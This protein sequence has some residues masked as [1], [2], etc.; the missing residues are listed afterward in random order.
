MR[1]WSAEY[2]ASCWSPVEEDHQTHL[3]AL[4]SR[5]ETL[6]VPLRERSRSILESP[7]EKR[8]SACTTQTAARA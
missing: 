8:V 3:E 2:G 4:A 5:R 6:S 1:N 7:A